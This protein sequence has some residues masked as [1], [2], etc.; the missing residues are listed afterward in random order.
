MKLYHYTSFVGAESILA[1][2]ITEGH[3]TMPDDR[4]IHQVV[5]MTTDP[6]VWGHGLP[7]GKTALNKD[8][9]AYATRVAGRE[10]TPTTK[11]HTA[12]RLTLDVPDDSPG[13]VNFR[14]YCTEV[15]SAI[16]ARSYGL[17]AIY[18]L[19]ALPDKELKRVFREAPSKEKTW[20][21]SFRPIPASMI[22][23]V[24]ANVDGRFVPYDF[25]Q[26]GRRRILDD[27]IAIP[28]PGALASLQQI[29]RPIR[30]NDLAK[31]LLICQDPAETPYAVIRSAR[32]NP[33]QLPRVMLTDN[34]NATP[35]ANPHLAAQLGRWRDQHREE[36]LGCW[37]Q[38][39]ER[40]FAFYP[41]ALP[42]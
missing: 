25:E 29:L 3:F 13:L 2:A 23:A 30:P 9:M 27:G 10:A 18:N 36:L 12:I 39:V 16:Y 37:N 31:A 41:D 14:K 40:Y 11:D 22:T 8:Q 4:V 42:A 15:A 5:W 24:E 6:R 38:A 28:G 32:L 34:S 20:W 19:K 1:S 7:D 26:H 33:G 35:C 17:S 21:L